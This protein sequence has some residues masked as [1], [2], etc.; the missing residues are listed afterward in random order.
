MGVDRDEEQ[1]DWIG[2]WV[3]MRIVAGSGEVSLGIDRDGENGGWIG[4]PCQTSVTLPSLHLR[5]R[6]TERDLILSSLVGQTIRGLQLCNNYFPSFRSAVFINNF[7]LRLRSI[8]L[9]VLRILLVRRNANRN[10][11]LLP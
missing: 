10:I 7:P 2:P 11:L 9:H 8:S 3:W 1:G 6:D 5:L 4:C